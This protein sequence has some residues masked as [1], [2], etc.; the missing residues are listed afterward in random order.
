VE[1]P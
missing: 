1:T